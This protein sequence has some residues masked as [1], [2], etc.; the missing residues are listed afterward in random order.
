MARPRLRFF[1]VLLFSAA[2]AC[3]AW[4]FLPSG[5]VD[6]ALVDVV[7]NSTA[8]PPFIV[9]GDGSRET[10][11]GLRVIAPYR[12]AD[13]KHLP[14]VISL[15]DDREG[16]FQSS[17]PSPVDL[18]I[19]VKNMQRLGAGKAGIS[20]VLAWEKPDIIALAALDSALAGFSALAT[21]APLS[22]SANTTQLPPSFRRASLPLERIDGDSSLL[23]A[24][25]RISLP[26]VILGG[27]SALSGFSILEQETTSANPPLIARWDDR[28]VFAFPVVAVLVQHGLSVDALEIE[29]GNF[30]KFGPTGPIIPIDP[31][32]RISTPPGK[33]GDSK[34]VRAEALI[35]A[36]QPLPITEN[37]FVLLR[38]DQSNSEAA[39]LAF[40]RK[41]APLIADISSGAGMSGE[42]KFHR[43]DPR[44][45]LGVLGVF[46]LALACLAP[47]NR[48]ARQIGFALIAAV[49]V[50]AHFI[51]T[52][53]DLWLPT[54]PVL[55]AT[56]AAFA[57]SRPFFRET[58]S[59]ASPAPALKPEAEP[60]AVPIPD[61]PALIEAPAPVVIEEPIAPVLPGSKAPAKKT[62][63]KKSP[64]KKTAAKKSPPPGKTAST[65]APAV[66]KSTRSRKKPPGNS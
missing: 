61:P 19:V 2:A 25:N 66:K 39:T 4:R 15:G 48:F 12:K 64:A 10:P 3:C 45:E 13:P 34:L 11:W 44:W 30:I 63:A 8:N 58:A 29:L 42:Q 49:A 37:S 28:A 36:A 35:D 7:A 47:K 65:K 24:V 60:A 31:Y 40:S 54:L 32:G 43:L 16:I 51:G 17:P 62:A 56:L 26:D 33:T 46:A 50:I 1:S 55:A 20:A 18:A 22:R 23:P 14:V 21:A 53:L 5:P 6:R 59:P 41:V 27:D 57:V 52:A 38:D 9:S